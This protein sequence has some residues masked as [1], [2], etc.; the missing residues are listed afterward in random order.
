MIRA[1]KW[2]LHCPHCYLKKNQESLEHAIRTKQTKKHKNA[3]SNQTPI[4]P[5]SELRPRQRLHKS[6]TENTCLIYV[7]FGAHT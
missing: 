3:N 1:K 6:H 4:D 5:N 7:R 2:N